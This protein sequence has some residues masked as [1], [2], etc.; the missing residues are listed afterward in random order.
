MG[1][2]FKVKAPPLN[3]LLYACVESLQAIYRQDLGPLVQ[4]QVGVQ[5]PVEGGKAKVTSLGAHDAQNFMV[6][7]SSVPA[8]S[9]LQVGGTSVKLDPCSLVIGMTGLDICLSVLDVQ[10]TEAPLPEA[11]T[12]VSGWLNEFKGL[13]QAV[14]MAQPLLGKGFHPKAA[15]SAFFPYFVLR[16][17]LPR[18]AEAVGACALIGLWYQNQA[19]AL[20]KRAN[21]V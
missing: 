12:T 13:P 6:V 4:R 20:V 18:D 17:D 9:P 7:Q 3:G 19:K 15:V 1:S 21:K 8:E 10:A 14:Q 2:L 5:P 16:G 11:A